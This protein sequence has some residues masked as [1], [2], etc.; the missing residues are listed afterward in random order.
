VTLA[1]GALGGLWLM[2]SPD[3]LGV[4]ALGSAFG[5]V[6]GVIPGLSGHFALAMMVT[7]L[8]GM[9]PVAGVALLLATH[10]TVSQGGGVT[11]ILFSTPGTGQ[12]AATLLDGPPMRDRGEGG[13]AIGAAMTACF[14]GAAFGA[15][16]LI[17]MIPVLREV[18]LIFGPPEVF[19]LSALGLIFV[20]VL[21]RGDL[22]RSLIAGLLG[23][24]LSLVGL[25]NA[26]NMPRF[27]FGMEWLGD[28]LALVPVVL[29]LFAVAEMLA[30][31]RRGGM[32]LPPG[33]ALPPP[34]ERRRQMLRGAWEVMARWPLVLRCSA[35]GTLI[36]VLPGIGSTTA[37]FVAYG[38]AKQ[39]SASPQ[40]FGRGN[41]EGIIGPEA[42]SDAEDGGALASTVAFGIPGSS[43]MAILLSGLTVLGLQTGP[44]MLDQNLD[45]L[46]VMIFTFV[47][48]NLIGTLMGVACASPLLR[49][50]DVSAH[51]LVAVV[52]ATVVT[53]A[54]AGDLSF[55]DMGV[56]LV[57]GLVGYLCVVLNYSRAAL[58]IGFVLGQ[59]I[60]YNLNL[61]VQ[62]DGPF[63]FL[64]PLP[65][66]LCL[67]GVA[68]LV[69]SAVGILREMRAA[70]A[71]GAV[72]AGA[73]D[74][75]QRA[76][77]L[78]TLETMWLVM[79]GALASGA[80]WETLSGGHHTTSVAL[81]VLLP[82]LALLA[83]QTRRAVALQA[84]LVRRT[85]ALRRWPGS[86]GLLGFALAV[87]GF[88]A[89]MLVAGHYAAVGLAVFA[90]VRSG[91]QVGS[92]RAAGVALVCTGTIYV[93]FDRLMGIGMWDGLVLRHLAGFQDF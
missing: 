4:I 26:T 14:A 62:I 33:V 27:I 84:G 78:L 40:T 31:W 5:F 57:F 55:A 86:E 30:L 8:Y 54:Y 63:F 61:A 83:V 90:V 21:G 93:L 66:A 15:A 13:V 38:H 18:I 7:L 36:G 85:A 22:L 46:F 39:T 79:W 20:A 59:P 44:A 9:D 19:L 24:F 72:P 32:L 29:G 74:D 41:I 48:A 70:K 23:L 67:V 87:A 56:A 49:A 68:F 71:G 91:G 11:A 25:D 76:A 69:H 35:I 81:T 77:D 34:R 52:L 58:L 2:S 65:L 43:S 17:L 6:V 64:A 16:V 51:V 10:A 75:P 3:V 92:G 82:L 42:A 37:A 53:A 88:L 47:V 73:A 50:T 60:E 89:L 12:N 28:G 1:E 45:I 80:L